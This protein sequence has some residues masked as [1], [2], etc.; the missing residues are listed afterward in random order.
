MKTLFV[1]YEAFQTDSARSSSIFNIYIRSCFNFTWTNYR[2][3]I[4]H[5]FISNL[6]EAEIIT[7]LSSISNECC[8]LK[9][10]QR[11]ESYKDGTQ[12]HILWILQI[13]FLMK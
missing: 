3:F 4:Q 9:M 1:S 5:K 6:I 11:C 7:A 12:L 2:N 13:P 10:G 8:G